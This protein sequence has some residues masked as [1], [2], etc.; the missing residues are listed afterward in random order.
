MTTHAHP[1]RER[2]EQQKDVL[3]NPIKPGRNDEIN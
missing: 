3:K 2:M 1:Q